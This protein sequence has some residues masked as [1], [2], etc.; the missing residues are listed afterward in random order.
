MTF[1]FWC[2]RA[3][4]SEPPAIHLPFGVSPF[5]WLALNDYCITL[6][7]PHV[8]GMAWIYTAKFS[9]K[10]QW[11]S[12]FTRTTNTL[13]INLLLLHALLFWNSYQRI[14][15]TKWCWIGGDRTYV[16]MYLHKFRYKIVSPHLLN[17]KEKK[18]VD[19]Y[20]PG[21]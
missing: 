9:D 2:T 12:S 13:I 1:G 3:P 21:E 16:C 4:T 11:S 7:K 10:H 8:D 6:I 5:H 14:H 19:T 15:D 18:N 17:D 20:F